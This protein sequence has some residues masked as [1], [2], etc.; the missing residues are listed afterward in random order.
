[1]LMSV[2]VKKASDMAVPPAAPQLVLPPFW[3]HDH[4]QYMDTEAGSER[5]SQCPEL[6]SWEVT[7]L[8]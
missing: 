2:Q 4:I 3:K 5:L 6:H 1:M 8:G 7:K